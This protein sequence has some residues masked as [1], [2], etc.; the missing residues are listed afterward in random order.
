[1]STVSQSG[2][3]AGDDREYDYIV[4]GSGI[5]GLFTAVL[6][7]AEGT[8]ARRVAVVTKGTLAQTNTRWA[9]G[10]IAAAV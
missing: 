5:A 9:Q 8:G 1:M 4:V 7:A 10:G 3:P 2:A 6:A